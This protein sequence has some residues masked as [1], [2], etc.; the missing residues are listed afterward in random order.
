MN[1]T[2]RNFALFS[3]HGKYNF[4]F[5]QVLLDFFFIPLLKVRLEYVHID[6]LHFVLLSS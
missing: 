6:L 2:E 5:S 3:I 4:R 1:W